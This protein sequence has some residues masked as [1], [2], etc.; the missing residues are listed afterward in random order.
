MRPKGKRTDV[1]LCLG[2]RP[3]TEAGARDEGQATWRRK[4]RQRRAGVSQPLTIL[5]VITGMNV[6]G[7]EAMLTKLVTHP[8]IAAANQRHEILSLMPLGVVGNRL[9]E[10][11]HA[12][13]T[14]GMRGRVPGAREMLRLNRVMHQVKPAIV[15]GW[16]HHGN[17]GAMVGR[18]LISPRPALMWNVRHSLEDI[19]REKRMTRHILRFE[20]RRSKLPTA[21]I[22]NSRIAAQQH[23]SIG[24]D[25]GRE[26]IIPNGFDCTGFQ[27]AKGARARLRSRFGIRSRATVVAMIARNHPMKAPEMLVA[28]VG[29]ARAAGHDLHL[30]MVGDNMDTPPP[31]LR[32]AIAAALPPDRVTLAGH[33]RDLAEW[34]PGVDILALP[35]AWGEGFPNILG[36][37][38]ACEVAC[39]TTDVG[40]SGL[41]VGKT[42]LVVPPRDH[43]AMAQALGRLERLGSEG[44]R[45][46]GRSARARV[47]S[48]YSL[49]DAVVRYTE[50]YARVAAG[51]LPAR[52]DAA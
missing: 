49:D 6:G 36:E 21:I 18:L 28:A 11:G 37:A 31:E 20:A 8:V 29:M 4:R 13:R 3:T 12:P 1:R 40:D 50:L 5:H 39:V 43:A 46:L 45:L 42:G 33:A 52:V 47:L 16:M 7:A 9:G 24:F 2:S 44:R 17:L 35:S 30:L 25:S 27:P 14:L 10:H 32:R 22:Y 51:A 38:M 41:I 48:E 26:T 15:Q 19:D 34:L 23:A